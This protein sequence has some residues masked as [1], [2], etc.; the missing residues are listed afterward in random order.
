MKTALALSC[1]VLLAVVGCDDDRKPDTSPDVNAG[2]TPASTA[3]GDQT[4]DQPAYE[5][6]TELAHFDTE[7]LDDLRQQAAVQGKVLVIDFWATWCG[8]CMVMFP[9]LHEAMH[10]GDRHERVMLVSVTQDDGEEDVAKAIRFVNKNQAG[11]GAYLQDQAS[12]DAVAGVINAMH[13]G[14]DWAGA[15][16]PAVF[17]FDKQGNLAHAMTRTEGEPADWVAE[18]AAAADR[19]AGQ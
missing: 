5:P 17:V 2:L 18:I 15:A 9:I 16:L 8:S 12:I 11:G 13:E 10:E 7:V 14:D 1:A 3:A 6:I 4:P 19:A